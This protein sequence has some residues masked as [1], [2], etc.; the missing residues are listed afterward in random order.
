MLALEY[1]TKAVHEIEILCS[2][3]TQ[4]LQSLSSHSILIKETGIVV[5][6]MYM[7]VFMQEGD[8]SMTAMRFE[9]DLCKISNQVIIL[10]IHKK[11]PNNLH[12]LQRLSLGKGFR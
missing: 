12:L 10:S 6:L 9:K 11:P 3:N 8:V 4:C 5:G 1:T 2:K 7:H